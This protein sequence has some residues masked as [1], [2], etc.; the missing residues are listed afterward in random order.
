MDEIDEDAWNYLMEIVAPHFC[1]VG[2]KGGWWG[3][4]GECYI[5]ID[6]K[7]FY[8]TVWESVEG[9]YYYM[10]VLPEFKD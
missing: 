10:G 8:M 1:C 7:P 6:G 3:Q 4:N 9:K 2:H 5:R